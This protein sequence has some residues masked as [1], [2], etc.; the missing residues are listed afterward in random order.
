[1]SSG[2]CYIGQF[3][4]GYFDGKGQL[5]D[6]KG[7]VFNG[8]FVKGKKEGFGLIVTNKGETIKGKYTNGIFFKIK[9]DKNDYI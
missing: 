8:N 9:N 6:K 3:K 5:T 2:D 1:M 4:N 7:N